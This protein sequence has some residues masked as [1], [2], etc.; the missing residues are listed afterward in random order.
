MDKR[1]KVDC[2]KLFVQIGTTAIIWF[3]GCLF[4]LFLIHNGFH[5]SWVRLSEIVLG[6]SVCFVG[7]MWVCAL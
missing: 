1:D 4:V 3:V 2:L 6:L 7:L 5:V